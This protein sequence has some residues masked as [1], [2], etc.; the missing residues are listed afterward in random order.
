MNKYYILFFTLFNAF[1]LLA[2]EQAGY[3]IDS[4][5]EKVIIY[6]C[7]NHASEESHGILY[8]SEKIKGK[9]I[10]SNNDLVITPQNLGYYDNTGELIY[11]SQS[12]VKELHFEERLF[13][14]NSISL[15]LDRLHEVIMENDKYILTN[16]YSRNHHFYIFDKESGKAVKAKV[17]HSVKRKDDYESLDRIVSK[18]FKDCEDILKTI[19]N[20]IYNSDY[21][22]VY[23]GSVKADNN[24]FK[25]INNYKCK[26][27]D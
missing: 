20:N 16:Y 6:Y 2:Q 21:R 24:M 1:N 12:Q 9:N 13:I 25:N 11:I 15:L 26:N 18:Y 17:K 23:G 14:N 4:K 27:N 7:K 22:I 3:Y 19:K 5:D 8:L 10:H